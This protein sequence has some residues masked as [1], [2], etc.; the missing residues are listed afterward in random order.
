MHIEIKRKEN[1]SINSLLYRFNKKVKQSGIMQEMKK[2][3]FYDRR[4]NRRKKRLAALYRLRKTEEN[5]R[6]AK[7][8]YV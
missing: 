5:A 7:F 6:L 3:R 8:G 2:R 4:I 1:E